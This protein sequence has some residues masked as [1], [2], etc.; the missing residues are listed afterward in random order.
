[1]CTTPSTTRQ[2]PTSCQ[3]SITPRVC[4][5]LQGSGASWAQT[6]AHL[7]DLLVSSQD[8]DL[9]AVG[10]QGAGAGVDVRAQVAALATA[11]EDVPPPNNTALTTA[12]LPNVSQLTPEQR[13]S[14][15]AQL[16][17]QQ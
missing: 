8:V 6:S 1:M 4:K 10:A 5:T 16:L 14:L 9:A 11:V 15:L 3:R 7:R 17:A 12:G 2:N 13:A